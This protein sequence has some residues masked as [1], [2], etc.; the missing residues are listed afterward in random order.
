MNNITGSVDEYRP[1]PI[2]E[3]DKLPQEWRERFAEVL[4]T[5]EP[6]LHVKI[7]R[8]W[9]GEDCMRARK[10]L[11]Q[12]RAEMY[13]PDLLDTLKTLREVAKEAQDTGNFGRLDG[14]M[15]AAISQ[16]DALIVRI[17]TG[18]NPGKEKTRVRK[19]PATVH[20]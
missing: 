16:T 8:R 1:A 9:S 18:I 11:E 13:G 6:D 12:V 4:R 19:R 3:A 15:E 7:Y 20:P 14:P 17:Q 5:Q 2:E 10:R